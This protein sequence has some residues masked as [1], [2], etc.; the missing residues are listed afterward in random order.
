MIKQT[1][2]ILLTLSIIGCSNEII[3]QDTYSQYK[4]T[5]IEQKP[6]QVS[7]NN[8][9]LY[10]EDQ[11]LFSKNMIAIGDIIKV[12]VTES[13]VAKIGNNVNNERTNSISMKIPFIQLPIFN[14]VNTTLNGTGFSTQ[15]SNKLSGKEQTDVTH[16]VNATIAVAI[17]NEYTTKNGKVFEIQG[18]KQVN[19]N[20]VPT[21]FKVMGFVQE[22]D[23]MIENKSLSISS[24]RINEL[25]VIQSNGE[26]IHTPALNTILNKY[27]P[28]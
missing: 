18:S 17:V 21:Y 19:V 4:N 13:T 8:G 9:T 14:K 12:I 1:A 25:I 2:S 10:K 27:S 5:L 3:Q 15:S 7:K 22:K 20:Q 24:D 11:N 28:L 16:S 23:I 26:S 6:I